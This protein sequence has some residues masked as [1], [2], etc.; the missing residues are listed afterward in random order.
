MRCVP[1]RMLEAVVG[2]LCL[3]K[4]LEVS[5]VVHCVLLYMLEVYYSFLEVMRCVLLCLLE[6]RRRWRWRRMHRVLLCLLVVLE[7]LEVMH[8]MLEV[9]EDVL[10][11]LEVFE[12]QE[13]FEV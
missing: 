1:P 8:C 9:E 6:V 10:C 4:V 13:V 3:P 11:L 7:G 2:R 5:E 12:A